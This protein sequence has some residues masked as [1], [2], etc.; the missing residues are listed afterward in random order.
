MDGCAKLN[1]V[2]IGRLVLCIKD[3]GAISQIGSCEP[4]YRPNPDTT[5]NAT[6]EAA[7]HP[8]ILPNRNHQPD[9]RHQRIELRPTFRK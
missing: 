1:F 6:H 7:P 2:G 3:P 4:S 9:F 8:V 5:I